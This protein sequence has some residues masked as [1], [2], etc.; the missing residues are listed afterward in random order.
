M[1]IIN[2]EKKRKMKPFK[3]K[4]LNHLLIKKVI[5]GEEFG[6]NNKKNLKLVIIIEIK[7]KLE[8]FVIIHVTK[9]EQHI[10]DMI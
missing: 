9:E 6:D 4:S 2:Y 3:N 1:N 5:C 10:A 8:I 7:A